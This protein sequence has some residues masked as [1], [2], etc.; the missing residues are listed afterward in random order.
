MYQALYRKWRPARFEDVVGQEHVTRTLRAQA[1]ADRLSHAYLFCG[2][3]GTGKT[4]CARILAKAAVC[5]APRDGDPCNECAAC[6]AVNEGT[7]ADVFE[8]DAATYTGVDDIR[9]LRAE[10]VYAPSALKKKVYI[11]DE[12]HMLSGSAFNAFLK[13]LEEPPEHVMFIL[14]STELHKI[15]ATVLSR[16]QRF[17]FA[18]IGREAIAQ[19]LLT[20]AAAEKIPLARSGAS[21]IAAMAD[22]AMR[23]ALSLLEQ[24]SAQSGGE[25]DAEAAAAAMGVVPADGL[26]A[27]FDSI[28][29]GDAAEA[30]R[31]FSARYAAGAEPEA[32]CDQ[33]LCL[34]RDALIAASGAGVDPIGAG[35]GPE[36]L[37]RYAA[38]PPERLLFVVRRVSECLWALPKSA[39]KRVDT[40]L[41]L[42]SL[43][44]PAVL[45][46]SGALASRVAELERRLA[47]GV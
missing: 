6:R 12:V 16:C 27:I 8:M 10:A 38:I 20:V 22:G 18:R 44:A 17:E 34:A 2:P 5:E 32:F 31:E 15:P 40:E 7:A 30:L 11:I 36:E 46:G 4:T 47:A 14:A 29:A 42:Y 21:L 26:F 25:L 3:R 43:C 13:I 45:D 19:R 39:D 33:L 41:C 1:A 28:L 9:A 24:V 23:N 35:Y 37:M